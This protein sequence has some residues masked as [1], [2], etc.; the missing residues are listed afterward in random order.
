M[1]PPHIL[2]V[3][4]SETQAM[5]LKFLLEDEGMSV[6]LVANAEDGLSFLDQHAPDLIVIDYFLPGMQG[7]AFCRLARMKPNGRRI[8]VLMLTANESDSPRAWV[9]DSGA[10]E[11]F[12]KSAPFEELLE[13]LQQLLARRR[14]RE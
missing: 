11:Y 8:P 14:R 2:V 12:S 7:D 9:L 4:D 6:S 10:D 5:K 13:R 3:E 1:I